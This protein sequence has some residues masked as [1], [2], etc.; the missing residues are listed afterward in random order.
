MEPRINTH[1]YSHP[2]FDKGNKN[3]GWRKETL[4]QNGAK[5]TWILLTPNRTGHVPLDLNINELKYGFK[6]LLS[7]LKLRN[8]EMGLTK[9]STRKG[10]HCHALT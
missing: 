3:I 8:L 10:A 6:T 1:S 9:G 7:H 2:T 5:K 4:Q